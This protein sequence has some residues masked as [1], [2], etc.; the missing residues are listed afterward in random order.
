MCRSSY[1]FEANW[2]AKKTLALMLA[3]LFISGAA[4]TKYIP[5]CSLPAVLF[6]ILNLSHV[7]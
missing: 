4:V 3:V 7:I 2:H 6:A 1:F 5:A